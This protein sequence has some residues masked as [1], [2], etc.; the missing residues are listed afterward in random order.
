MQTKSDLDW[1]LQKYHLGIFLELVTGACV[2]TAILLQ[3]F[4]LLKITLYERQSTPNFSG[5]AHKTDVSI[6]QKIITM[7]DFAYNLCDVIF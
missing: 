7:T 1:H 2:K 3:S 5:S 4:E 6:K